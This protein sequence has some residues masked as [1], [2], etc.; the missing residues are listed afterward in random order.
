MLQLKLRKR[1]RTMTS[2]EPTTMTERI[3]DFVVV[4]VPKTIDVVDDDE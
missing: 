3:A 1:R 2:N 4:A